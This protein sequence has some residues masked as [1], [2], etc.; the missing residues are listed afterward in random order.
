MRQ[1]A[2][3]C[4]KQGGGGQQGQQQAG[5]PQAFQQRGIMGGF[6][7]G[8]QQ[9]HEAQAAAVAQ[10]TQLLQNDVLRNMQQQS[11]LYNDIPSAVLQSLQVR[12]VW[13]APIESGTWSVFCCTGKEADVLPA[14]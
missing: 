8:L 1:H 7:G 2:V 14:W 6:H 10:Q 5:Q 13:A 12:K 9:G 3:C 4:A 11:R